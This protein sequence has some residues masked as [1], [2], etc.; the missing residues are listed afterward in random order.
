MNQN[1]DQAFAALKTYQWGQQPKLVE[2]IEAAIIASEGKAA[3]R[4]EIAARLAAVLESDAPHDAK[5]YACRRLRVVGTPAS[6]PA[7]AALLTDENLSHMARWA[8]ERM[9]ADQAGD[10]LRDALGQ[11]D[12]ELKIGIMSSLA[13]RGESAS[14][15]PL[16]A[17]LNHSDAAV[18]Q[19]AAQAL[20][21]IGTPEAAKALRAGMTEQTQAIATDALLVCAERALE[22][23]NKAEALALYKG[24][25]KGDQ[26]KHVRLAASR[27]LLVCAGQ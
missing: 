9:S 16:A 5:Q 21:V 14:I 12:G 25:A 17:L 1:L 4:G 27:G 20:G 13:T 8:L 15:A 26:P 18:A 10:A 24:L 11:V 7:L 19:S 6:V 2:P 23:G 3:Q 22:G